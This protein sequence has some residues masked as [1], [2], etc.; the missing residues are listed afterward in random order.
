MTPVAR[1]VFRGSDDKDDKD[2]LLI[3]A[4]MTAGRRLFT[5]GHV[6]E[7]QECMGEFLIRDVGPSWVKPTVT[8]RGPFCWGN[9]VVQLLHAG[10]VLFLSEDEYDDLCRQSRKE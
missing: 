3:G 8:R 5:P 4:L 6:Y 9:S 10:K 1:F 2:G 7:V